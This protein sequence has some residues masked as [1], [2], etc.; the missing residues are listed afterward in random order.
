MAEKTVFGRQDLHDILLG[1]VLLSSGGGG[2]YE[3]GLD[4][5]EKI[6][7][8]P[9][10]EIKCIAI[11]EFGDDDWA[12]VVAPVG[13]P[14]A[15]R[16]NPPTR[17]PLTA[18]RLLEEAVGKQFPKTRGDQEAFEFKSVLPIETGSGA[19]F[20]ALWIAGYRQIPILDADGGG[21]AFP[22]I[23]LCTY[24]AAAEKIKELSIA[25]VVLSTELG[26]DEGGTE[27]LVEQDDPGTIDDLCRIV[28]VNDVFKSIAALACYPM[29][30]SIVKT[31]SVVYRGGVTSAR[32]V[33][34]ILREA[35]ANGP[36]EP[37]QLVKNIA[38]V[39]GRKVAVLSSGLVLDV[40]TES[41]GGF[42]FGTVTIKDRDRKQ[43]VVVVNQNENLIAWSDK[44]PHPIAMAPDLICYVGLDG[45][46]YSNVEIGD[47]K[48]VI[49]LGIQ[50]PEILRNSYFVEGYED[51]VRT[52]GYCG[53][54]VW[55]DA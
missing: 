12:A 32:D 34:K 24:A 19:H 53:A 44:K 40:K 20:V 38:R 21:R 6:L 35:S 17:G 36:V 33:G 51:V 31:E 23:P 7:V 18:F 37:D 28:V 15:F 49:L 3:N 4:L 22:K 42:D 39:L 47:V 25:P 13:S 10:P 43:N 45:Q 14:I 11:D 55:F 48:E 50:A 41:H 29:S 52:M 16:E 5:L 9:V 46:P 26:V 2:S 54:H 30:G 1:D 8:L 27:V